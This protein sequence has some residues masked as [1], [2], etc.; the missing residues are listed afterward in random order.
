MIVCVRH[1][2]ELEGGAGGWSPP[3]LP[4]KKKKFYLEKRVMYLGGFFST[5]F[6]SMVF[7][8]QLRN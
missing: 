4:P 8:F 3:P 7:Y 2:G 5:W 6:L 1:T